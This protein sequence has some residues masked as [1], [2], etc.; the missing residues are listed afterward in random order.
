MTVAM[1]KGGTQEIE[2]RRV[3]ERPELPVIKQE[4][5]PHLGGLKKL[6]EMREGS[7]G[8]SDL[9]SEIRRMQTGEGSVG[10]G[11]ITGVFSRKDDIY[12]EGAGIAVKFRGEG[13]ELYYVSTDNR[14]ERIAPDQEKAYG[15]EIY[16]MIL[17]FME[18]RARDIER[19]G[20][21]DRRT[22]LDK[23]ELRGLKI[24]FVNF[25]SN[26]D[27]GARISEMRM[28][29]DGKNALF[30]DG[31]KRVIKVIHTP[32]GKLKRINKDG[33]LEEVND[34]EERNRFEE[35]I[36]RA[37]LDPNVKKGFSREK[38]EEILDKYSARTRVIQ[39]EISRARKHAAAV[40][41]AQESDEEKKRRKATEKE[42][43]ERQ[44]EQKKQE[45]EA[46]QLLLENPESIL[47]L[48]PKV[49]RRMER[50]ENPNLVE[51]YQKRPDLHE[52]VHKKAA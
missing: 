32:T 17:D 10:I 33:E 27:P 3:E 30:S 48:D 7:R 6:G 52:K 37:M 23:D 46:E 5:H 13:V 29:G 25:T 15:R 12:L 40:E 50:K 26:N 31:D 9:T 42:R 35:E 20:K 39:A 14:E 47:T 43:R 22:D 1:A 49:R 19:T 36:R 28:T 4:S 8:F 34:V 11:R 51:L 2:R 41:Y 24:R 38:L 18:E 45:D 16:Y 44:R 21:S